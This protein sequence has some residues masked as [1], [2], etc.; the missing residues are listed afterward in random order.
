[1]KRI[2]L[3]SVA[4]TLLLLGFE[5]LGSSNCSIAQSNNKIIHSRSTTSAALSLKIT[6][7]TCQ[8]CA[9]IIQRSLNKDNGVIST[10]IKYKNAL[11]T[12]NYNPS[13]TNVTKIISEIEETGYKAEKIDDMRHKIGSVM[14][15]CADGCS[16]AK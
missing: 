8:N 4:L 9:Q 13:K 7:M 16:T 10:D 12:V 14:L 15:R 3:L 6:G 11:N 1:M 5:F 2:L